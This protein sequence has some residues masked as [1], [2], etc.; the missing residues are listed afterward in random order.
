MENKEIKG[1]KREITQIKYE[2]ST[3]QPDYRRAA[4]YKL[5]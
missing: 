3:T 4:N 2:G 5:Q 1:K